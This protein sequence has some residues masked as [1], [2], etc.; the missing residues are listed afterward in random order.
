MEIYPR[1]PAPRPRRALQ[2]SLRTLLT[3]VTIIA[4]GV[5]AVHRSG[6][7]TVF[8]SC[9]AATLGTILVLIT[10]TFAGPRWRVIGGNGLLWAG[11]SIVMVLVAILALLK[12]IGLGF[13]AC[14]FG[15]LLLLVGVGVAVSRLH[16]AWAGTVFC[17]T[18]GLGLLLA[19]AFAGRQSQVRQTML[20]L[21][22][23]PPRQS[24]LANKQAQT[25]TVDIDG[26]LLM[27][28][29]PVFSVVLGTAL[30]WGLAAARE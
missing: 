27:M 26:E 15:S 16:R 3:L 8:V 30:G 12:P 10:L 1:L 4:I 11:V 5:A 21:H 6:N 14:G 2:F 24:S 29:L 22:A 28:A 17:L 7:A 23:P 13:M 19:L 18:V 9:V 20:R 25:K